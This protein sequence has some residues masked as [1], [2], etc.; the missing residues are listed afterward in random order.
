[1]CETNESVLRNQ[2]KLLEF[3]KRATVTLNIWMFVVSAME[4]AVRSCQE[5]GVDGTPYWDVAVAVYTGS[6]E[7][8][9]GSGDG[10]LL[11]ALADEECGNFGTCDESVDAPTIGTSKVNRGIFREF[12]L[13]QSNLFER[14]CGAVALNT[15]RAIQLMMVPLVQGYLRYAYLIDA[16]YSEISDTS[17]AFELG[18]ATGAAFSAAILPFIFQCN[19]D[20]ASVVYSA[21]QKESVDFE[22]IKAALESTYACL[23]ITC[24][25][26]GGL[27]D[28]NNGGYLKGAAP[29]GD[30]ET[31]I[32]PTAAPRASIA[33][34]S[35]SRALSTLICPV[36]AFCML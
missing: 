29:C 31:T 13:G 6:L 26:V 36:L 35:I 32:S 3:I 11:Y 19:E 20:S 30:T 10:T 2:S 24:E 16:D 15:H 34:R 8:K 28:P 14:Q 27:I 17:G 21:F 12:E 22:A 7:G 33:S 5:E 4:Y 9:D 25:D 1:M 23:G 18:K